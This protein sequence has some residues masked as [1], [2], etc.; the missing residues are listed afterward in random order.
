M[1]QIDEAHLQTPERRIARAVEPP[2]SPLDGIPQGRNRSTYRPESKP[3]RRSATLRSVLAGLVGAALYGSW[4]FVVNRDHG[5][6]VAL[7]AALTQAFVSF[8]A[9]FAVTATMETLARTALSLPLRF[10]FSSLGGFGL[11]ALYTLGMHLW[12]GTPEVLKTAAPS[13][14]VG[15]VYCCIYSAALVRANSMQT[16]PPPDLVNEA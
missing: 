14:I 4:A 7:T 11:A 9:T 1:N 13:L 6:D 12:M 2:H 3:E 10:L 16:T 15:S 5:A 8:S